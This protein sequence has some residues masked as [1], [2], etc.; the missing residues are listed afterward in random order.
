MLLLPL[1]G[2]WREIWIV[3]IAFASFR[4]FDVW[5]PPPCHQL[6]TLPAGWGILMDDLMAAVYANVLAQLVTRYL[7]GL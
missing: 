5:K 7:F 4:I 1:R 6:E 2:D 3:L